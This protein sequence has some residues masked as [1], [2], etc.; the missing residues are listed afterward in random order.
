MLSVLAVPIAR[1]RRARALNWLQDLFP[2]VAER[3]D[4]GG[5]ISRLG[6]AALRRLRNASLRE[7]AGNIVLGQRMAD[8]LVSLGVARARIAIIPNWADGT[9]IRPIERA[10]NPLR[11][12]WGLGGHF[13]VGYSGNLGR[14]HDIDTILEAVDILARGPPAAPPIAWLFVGGG[15]QLQ[16]LR[17]RL[18]AEARACVHFVPYQPREML[19]QSLSAADVHLVLLRPELEG[20]IVPS[21]FYG[22]AAAGRPTIF[23]GDRNGE[24]PH[25]LARTGCG[26]S[27]Q[28]GQAKA[29]ADTV[30]A[31]ASNPSRCAELGTAARRAFEAEFDKPIAIARWQAA[32]VR[33]AEGGSISSGD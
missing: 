32:L 4:V 30:A 12:T 27:I 29:L 24:I 28:Q 7:A 17:G 8:R 9:V 19:A 10:A 1:L 15:N 11:A 5:C 20:L 22:I 3:L 31:L 21:K 13:V 16:A 26:I 14:A 6:F 25:I 33:V 23:V 2:E 18:S